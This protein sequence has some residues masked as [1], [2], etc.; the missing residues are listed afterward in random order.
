MSALHINIPQLATKQL[1]LQECSAGKKLVVSTNWLPLFGFEKDAKVIEEL[2]GK[3]EGICV[4]LADENAQKAKKVYS[5][6]YKSRRNNPLE[7]MLDIRSQALI[8]EAFPDGTTMV[9]IVFE[10]GLITITPIEDKKAQ[11]IREFKNTKE[12][13]ST[14]LAC[15][16]GVD[17][18]ALSQKGFKIETLI[19]Y[20]PNE[21]RD[22]NDLSE[23][24]ALNALANVE[25]NYLINEDIM[26]LNMDKLVKLTNKSTQTLLHISLQCDDFSNVKA[27]SLKDSHVEDA[28]STLDMAYDM[29]RLVETFRFPTVLLEN[30]RGFS[31][32]DV[33]KMVQ[34]RLQRFGYKVF[35]GIYDARDFG[36]MTSRVRNYMF[37]TL[38]PA[39][40]DVT[41]NKEKNLTSLWDK[42][43]EPRIV[44]GEL[45]DVS[46]SKS[47]KDGVACGRA[48]MIKRDSLFS[49]TFLKSQNRMAKDS[50]IIVDEIRDKVYFPSNEL[51]KELMGVSKEMCFDAVGGSI[52]NEIIG[53][54]VEV[55][56]HDAILDAIREHIDQA[57]MRLSGRLL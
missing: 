40:F 36:G 47:L 42:F 12:K 53:Q 38:L 20:R 8:Q 29:L 57:S 33:G 17:G 56:L 9:H 45:R 34:L 31:T 5:R 35:D 14:F 4:K 22:H 25:V 23:T 44:T 37:A 49:P 1:K 52:E 19:E 2:I 27:K 24:G 16:S 30:V 48:R 3:G 7:T 51:I 32:S 54:S 13:L 21:K 55:P 15:S 50:V 10:Q 46:H 41:P 11:A 6:E 28:T 39:P 18:Y 43:I 26:N